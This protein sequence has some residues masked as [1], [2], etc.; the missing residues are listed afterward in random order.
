M[1]FVSSISV[2]EKS[3][4]TKFMSFGVFGFKIGSLNVSSV[5][6]DK[7]DVLLRFKRRLLDYTSVLIC[8][9]HF[10]SVLLYLSEDSVF[11]ES[12]DVVLSK[13]DMI[14]A[15]FFRGHITPNF[16]CSTSEHYI[17]PNRI[18]NYCFMY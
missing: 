1:I 7:F 6:R 10:L 16:G 9:T 4:F 14:S 2:S 13:L 17:Y 8:L 18:V 15:G 12:I 3:T 11:T 5:S